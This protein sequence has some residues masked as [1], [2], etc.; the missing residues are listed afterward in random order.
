M[1][2]VAGHCFLLQL[3]S[4][5]RWYGITMSCQG[6]VGHVWWKEI[7]TLEHTYGRHPESDDLATP[8]GAGRSS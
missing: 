4:H 8:S 3:G 7:E 6:I 2:I 1:V 5:S